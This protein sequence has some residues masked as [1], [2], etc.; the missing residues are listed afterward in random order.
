LQENLP[1]QDCKLQ[2]EVLLCSNTG[3]HN[4]HLFDCALCSRVP[5]VNVC[6]CVSRDHW[7][8]YLYDVTYNLLIGVVE[9]QAYMVVWEED[10]RFIADFYK[11]AFA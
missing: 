9:E 1:T 4:L 3:W 5:V 2:W 10:R 7:E 6:H 8:R 11:F